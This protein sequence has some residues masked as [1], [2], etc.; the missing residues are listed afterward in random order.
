MLFQK[1][2]WPGNVRELE[3]TIE[4]AL[5][6]C[7]CDKLT[8]DDFGDIV[9]AVSK[10]GQ[11]DRPIES[12][13]LKELEKQHIIA[14]MEGCRGNQTQAARQLGVGRNTLW[15]KLKEYDIPASS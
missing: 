8:E 6:F 13:T 3:H 9:A 1:Y 15:R 12:L 2:A 4:R 10:G 14:A 11:P 7:R 5:I